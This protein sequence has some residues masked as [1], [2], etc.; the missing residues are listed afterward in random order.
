MN[1]CF[2]IILCLTALVF[3]GCASVRI[4]DHPILSN[5]VT[6]AL[7]VYA[8]NPA[9]LVQTGKDDEGKPVYDSFENWLHGAFTSGCDKLRYD[10]FEPAIVLK[11]AQKHEVQPKECPQLS[12]DGK[13]TQ[14]PSLPTFE[15]S[16]LPGLMDASQDLGASH[17]LKAKLIKYERKDYYRSDKVKGDFT[18]VDVTVEI[19]AYQV[20]RQQALFEKTFSVSEDNSSLFGEF[21]GGGNVKK[22]LAAAVLKEIRNNATEPSK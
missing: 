5:T 20:P 12:I 22:E 6:T 11:F 8:E 10:Y 15:D 13:A 17:V 3:S 21:Y 16:D 14:L 19:T 1:S 7:I 2:R 18:R 4:L 9:E